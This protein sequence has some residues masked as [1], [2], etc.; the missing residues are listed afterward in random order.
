MTEKA[1][2]HHQAR[3]DERCAALNTQF[4]IQRTGINGGS[5]ETQLRRG[6]DL[7]GRGK[8]GEK[9]SQN[10][11]W[12]LSEEERLTSGGGPQTAPSG[13]FPRCQAWL[14][15]RWGRTRWA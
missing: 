8:H 15:L 9:T 11:Q 5:A 1:R 3:G 14:N 7:R 12:E 13:G 4:D 10:T 2:L 6:V